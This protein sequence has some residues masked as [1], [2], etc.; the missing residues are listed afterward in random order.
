M[1]DAENDAC[2]R[3]QKEVVRTLWQGAALGPYQLLAL[4]SFADRGCQPEVYTYDPSLVLPRWIVRKSAA[5]I[6]PPELVL[7]YLRG[8]RRFAIR[9]DL[10]RWALLSQLGGWWIDP[11]V[12]L[13]ASKL[14]QDDLF[15]SCPTE[16]GLASTAVLKFPAEHSL[17]LAAMQSAMA[18]DGG[19]Q[20]EEAPF[21]AEI[22]ERHGVASLCQPGKSVCPISWFDVPRLF[23]PLK[24][25]ELAQN[26]KDKPF[27]DLHYEVWLRSGVPQ[28]LGPPEGS[29]LDL[30]LQRHNIDIQFPAR[31]EFG[32]LVRWMGHMYEVLATRRHKL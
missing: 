21:R 19:D 29:F 15:I 1:P 14:P 12:V 16:F 4:R 11:D 24:G 32:N 30:L 7:R 28:Y 3:L 23:D 17:P 18:S 27:L 8:E 22:I 6:L 13:L 26:L 25:G 5:A 9:S 31:L 2:P 10:F 20:I